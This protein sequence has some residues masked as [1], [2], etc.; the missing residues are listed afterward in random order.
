M[1]EWGRRAGDSHESWRAKVML[2]SD[3]MNYPDSEPDGT[4]L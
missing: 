1:R 4:S 3:G 2:L